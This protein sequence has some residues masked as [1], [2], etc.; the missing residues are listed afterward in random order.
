MHAYN[1]FVCA[2]FAEEH[3]DET[4]AKVAVRRFNVKL[5]QQLPLEDAVFYGMLNE[6]ELLPLNA[7]AYIE[8]LNTRAEKVGYFLRHVI[9]PAASDTLPTLIKV[10]KK[11]KISNLAKLATKI[12]AAVEP[13]KYVQ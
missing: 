3:I 9:E 7:G 1:S 6:A 8:T 13:G 5:L 2:C 10:M 4:L 11:C 12:Q